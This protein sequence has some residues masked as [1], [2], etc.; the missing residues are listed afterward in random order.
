MSSRLGIWRWLA[1]AALVLSPGSRASADAVPQPAALEPAALVRSALELV[2]AA[3]SRRDLDDLAS[4]LIGHGFAQRPQFSHMMG[5]RRR[6]YALPG[7]RLT[8][9]WVA[10]RGQYRVRAQYDGAEGA[11]PQVLAIV[12][13]HCRLRVARRLRYDEN[14]IAAWLDHLDA[15]WRPSRPAEPLN[16][17]VPAHPDPGGVPVALVDTGVNYLLPQINRGLARDPSGALLGYDYWDL[18]DRPFDFHPQRSPFLPDRHGTMIASLVLAEAPVAR[19][20][21]FRYPG[22]DM[23]R[24]AR[25]VDAAA[26]DGAH[27]VN[28]SLVGRQRDDWRAFEEAAARHPEV[29]FVVAA[30]NDGRN[31][32][33]VPVYPAALPL[34]NLITVTAA[35]ADGRLAP[36][37]NWG[38]ETVD[39]M[40]EAERVWVLDFD[41]RTRQVS[42]SSYATARLTALAACLLAAHPEWPSAALKA[43]ILGYA[44]PAPGDAQVRYGFIGNPVA[45]QRGACAGGAPSSGL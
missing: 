26:A 37:V 7:G 12:D 5:G 13:D 36:G 18:D 32:D 39:L 23:T 8:V 16:P 29:L 28:L 17:P 33:R 41:G 45:R 42:G 4:R 15:G 2:C 11:Q 43:R 35:R 10:P 27:L 1:V 6:V 24:M 3:R 31:I 25:L 19:V 14:G 34:D 38:R 22:P 9:D 44:R 30:G 21:P 20:L 40:V